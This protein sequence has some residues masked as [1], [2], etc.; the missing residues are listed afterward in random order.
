SAP[1]PARAPRQTCLSMAPAVRAVA[2]VRHGSPRRAPWR[3]LAQRLY[4]LIQA[5]E[6][7]RVHAPLGK[8]PNQR[9]RGTLPPARLGLRI[10]PDEFRVGLHQALEP[11]APRLGIPMLDAAARIGD[12]VRAHGRIADQYELVIRGVG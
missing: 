2:G 11:D 4:R 10:D 1:S 5:C 7:Q 12:L 6:R 8:L 3:P 9:D